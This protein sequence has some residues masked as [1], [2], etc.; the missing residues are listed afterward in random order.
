MSEPVITTTYRDYQRE[1]RPPFHS[2]PAGA[3]WANALGVVKDGFADAARFARRQRWISRCAEDALAKHGKFRGWSKV[4]GETTAQYRARLLAW[5]SL[6]QKTGTGLG[7]RD[8]FA[9]LGMTNVTIREAL[10]PTW[11]RYS[12]VGATSRQRWFSVIIR[13]P[14]PF[15]VTGEFVYGD[16]TTYGSGKKYGLSGDSSLIEATKEIVRRMRPEHAWCG[17]IIV[18][19]A[20]DII[21]GTGTTNDG[22]PDTTLGSK[23]AYLSIA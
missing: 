7:I 4:A 5:W 8:A 1:T 6:S 13:H 15:G 9:L 22:K 17:D 19:L 16:G 3:A 21:D 18:V 2:G 14:H 11:G 10:S 23:V 12:G 20:G